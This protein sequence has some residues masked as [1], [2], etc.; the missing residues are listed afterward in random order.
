M[1][2]WTGGGLEEVGC[3]NTGGG[4][5]EREQGAPGRTDK[6]GRLRAIMRDMELENCHVG[7]RVGKNKDIESNG[8]RVQR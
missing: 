4:Q 2:I 1:V 7:R 3:Q 5:N 6:A 8:S